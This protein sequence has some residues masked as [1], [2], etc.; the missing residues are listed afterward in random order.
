VWFQGAP[1][2]PRIPPLDHG[3]AKVLDPMTTWHLQA[4]AVDSTRGVCRSALSMNRLDFWSAST[5]SKGVVLVV[6]DLGCWGSSPGR[7]TVQSFLRL[8]TWR[9]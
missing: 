5:S 1:S 7:W 6:S 4:G 3:A 8:E 2:M 9:W